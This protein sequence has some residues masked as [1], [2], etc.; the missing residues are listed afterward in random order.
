MPQAGHLEALQRQRPRQE[1]YFDRSLKQRGKLV[2]RWN[3]I[4][5][6]QILERSWEE[7]A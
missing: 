5:P 2:R 1:R 6:E 4:V 3:L 7:V